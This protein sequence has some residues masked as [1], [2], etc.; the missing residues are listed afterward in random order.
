MKLPIKDLKFVENEENCYYFTEAMLEDGIFIKLFADYEEVCLEVG[1]LSGFDILN[2]EYFTI[3]WDK[4]I[5]PIQIHQMI[6]EVCELYSLHDKKEFIE[7]VRN[8]SEQ[9]I[10]SNMQLEQKQKEDILNRLMS[11]I[12]LIQKLSLKKTS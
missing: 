5:S 7:I 1:C 12:G 6:K 9:H 8:L 4:V 11:D 3:Y 10:S 2:A